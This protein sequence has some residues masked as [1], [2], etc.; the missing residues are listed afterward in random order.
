MVVNCRIKVIT[1]FAPVMGVNF[2]NKGVVQNPP[3]ESN[4]ISYTITTDNENIFIN[5]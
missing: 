2:S 3:A 1:W 5:L 4:L